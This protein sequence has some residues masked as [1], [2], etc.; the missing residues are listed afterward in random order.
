MSRKYITS[1][2]NTFTTNGV[3]PPLI[4]PGTVPLSG[5]V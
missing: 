3:E 5:D 2:E 1:L 4:L